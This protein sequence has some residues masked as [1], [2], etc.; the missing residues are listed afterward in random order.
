MTGLWIAMGVLGGILLIGYVW[1]ATIIG[2]RNQAQQALSTIDVELRKRHDLL[3]NI[4]KLAQRFMTHEKA[5]LEELTALRARV[6]QPY[7][8]G[9]AAA[10][11]QHLDAAR[12]LDAGMMRLFAVAENY[13][14]LKSADTILRAQE[15]FEEVEGHISAARRFYNAAVTSLNNAIQIFPGSIIAG[16]AG[17][18]ALPFYEIEPEARAPVNVDDYMK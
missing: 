16:M 14:E 17:V 12:A 7:Q 11:K 15:T 6:S 4:L 3:P 18:A 8:A 9:D 13:P 1:Y 10:V 5:L 2:R